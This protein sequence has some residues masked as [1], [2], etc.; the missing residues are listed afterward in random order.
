LNKFRFDLETLWKLLHLVWISPLLGFLVVHG[1]GKNFDKL[2]PYGDFI[3]GTTVPILTFVS[4]LAVVITLRMQ[5]DQLEMQRKELQNSIEEMKA[6][7]KEF[8]EQNVTLSKQR[9]DNTF[10]QMINLHNNIVNSIF[11]G[12]Q[13]AKTGRPAVTQYYLWYKTTYTSMLANYDF[14]GKD[15]ITRIRMAFHSFFETYEGELSHYFK[16]LYETIKFLDESDLE[17][18]ETYV[19]IIKAQLSP[20]EQALILYYSLS[21]PGYNF[22]TYLK[23]FN[24]LSDLNPKILILETHFDE[25]F[26]QAIDSIGANDEKEDH[27]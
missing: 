13:H 6:T 14:N 7:R 8:E 24:L 2:G 15:E 12:G 21:I 22:L 27:H 25:V 5:R 23:K 16:N 20:H 17:T 10:F 26:K 18:K 4:F 19:G 11:T 9:F 3:A 1:A